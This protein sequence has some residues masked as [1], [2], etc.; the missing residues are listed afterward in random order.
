MM[1]RTFIAIT[2]PPALQQAISA[3]REVFQPFNFPWRWVTP[4][5]IHLTMKFL[6][7]IPAEQVTM[8]SKTMEHAVQGHTAFTLRA[9][10]LGCFPHPARPRVLW[11]GL[12]DSTH[13]LG[14]INEGLTTALMHIG[15]PADDGLFHPHLTLARAQNVVRSDQ[16]LPVLQTYQQWRFGEFPVTQFHL[17]QSQLQREGALH[18]ILHSVTLRS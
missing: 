17:F 3:V 10:S 16:F 8:L 14:L 15:F 2:P 4:G 5:Q 18:T 1:I 7:D 12:T 13:T 6:G 11:I 9:Q